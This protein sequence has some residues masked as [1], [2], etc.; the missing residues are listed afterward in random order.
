MTTRMTT[1]ATMTP[2]ITDTVG[3]AGVDVDGLPGSREH[4][5]QM[6]SVSLT[7]DAVSLVARSLLKLKTV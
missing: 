7:V 4:A 6:R 3:H 5:T 2:T 1:G